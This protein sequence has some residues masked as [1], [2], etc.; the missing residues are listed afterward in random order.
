MYT[1]GCLEH[2]GPM[3][4]V[5]QYAETKQLNVLFISISLPFSQ[6]QMFQG[7]SELM[8]EWK[9]SDN[10]KKEKKITINQQGKTTIKILKSSVC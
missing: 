10:K 8:E 9:C 3:V 2:Q 6:A 4:F 1:I 5:T 7:F